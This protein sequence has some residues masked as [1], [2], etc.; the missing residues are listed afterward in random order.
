[1]TIVARNFGPAFR[2]TWDAGVSVVWNFFLS[3]VTFRQT[4]SF[5]SVFRYLGIIDEE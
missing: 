4:E 5:G 1:M 2:T 3:A